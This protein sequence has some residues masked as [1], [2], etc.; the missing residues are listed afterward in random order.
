MVLIAISPVHVLYAQEAREYSLWIVTILLCCTALI[1]AV[2]SQKRMWWIVYSFS[3]GL[4][5]YVSLLS[6]LLACSQIIYILLLSRLRINKIT[7][8]FLKHN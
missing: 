7:R 1:K 5:L 6:I 2:K 8:N 3:L 4:N